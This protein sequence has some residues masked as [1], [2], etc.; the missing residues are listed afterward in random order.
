MKK[1]LLAL[2]TLAATAGFA[3]AANVTLYGAADMA[4]TYNYSQVKAD[5]AKTSEQSYGLS[6]G[7]FGASKFGL[8]GVE[9]LG[10]GYSVG[11]KLENGFDADT[12]KLG[13][14]GRLFGREATLTV[15]TPF[16]N[17]SAGRMGALSSGAGTYDIFQAYG[18]VFDGGVG[19]IGAGY[20]NGTGRYDNMLAYVTPDLSGLKLYAQ[21]GFQNDG[22]EKDSARDNNRYWGVG[23]TF[24][25]GPLGLVAVVDSV[26]AAH[27]KD[28][29]NQDEYT[30]S[31][32]GNYDFGSFKPF[33]G[34][35]YGEHLNSFGFS[36]KAVYD[37]AAAKMSDLKGYALSV[38][39][40]FSLPCGTLSAVLFYAHTKG[41]LKYANTEEGESVTADLKK[42]NVYG[43]GLVHGYP[44]SKR[45]T[46][47]TGVGYTYGKFQSDVTVGDEDAVGS[48][49]K[50]KNAQVLFGL[51]HTF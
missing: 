41:D 36:D 19:D 1:T 15:Y 38:G 12:G 6:S 46:L 45:T 2:A 34:V 49:V 11:F 51:N 7:N 43:V 25:H 50:T 35:Q 33:V 27:V 17:V 10:N 16:G 42:G 20:W 8:K 32:G 21:Y 30:L 44:L 13:Q 5:G 28:G 3:Q 22:T 29:K 37:G 47:Y 23:A 4:L 40:Q 48:T 14:D 31:L 26:Q 9:E 39:S 18:D 24:D